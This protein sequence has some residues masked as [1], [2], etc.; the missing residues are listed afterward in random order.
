MVVTAKLLISKC[1]AHTY[2]KYGFCKSYFF[3]N[4]TLG[5][6]TLFSSKLDSPVIKTLETHSLNVKK[7][8]SNVLIT[9]EY[10][11]DEKSVQL[12]KVSFIKK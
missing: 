7:C 4:E 2:I 9:G 1:T 12:P 10:N 8:V 11:F 6:W 5:S 3:T